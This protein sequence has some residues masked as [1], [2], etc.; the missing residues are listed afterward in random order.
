MLLLSV[1][2]TKGKA[3]IKKKYNK[4]KAI[5]TTVLRTEGHYELKMF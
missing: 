3:N 4:T 5:T 1:Y 2:Q